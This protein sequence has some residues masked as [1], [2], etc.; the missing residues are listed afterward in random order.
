MVWPRPEYFPFAST[1]ERPGFVGL[2]LFLSLSACAGLVLAPRPVRRWTLGAAGAAILLVWLTKG[3]HPP[4]ADLNAA[5]Y[6]HVPGMWLF[7]EPQSKSGPLLVALL[8]LGSALLVGEAGGRWARRGLAGMLVGA[9]LATSYPIWTGSVIPDQRPLLPPA[10]V[11]FPRYWLETGRYLSHH[12]GRVL[13]LPPDDYYQVP[14]RWGFY[15]SDVFADEL[16]GLVDRP[17]AAA[18]GQRGRWLGPSTAQ[19]RRH[20]GGRAGADR[21]LSATRRGLVR[22]GR[23]VGGP[24]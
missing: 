3:L 20:L 23:G 6:R 11:R 16:I 12:P 7:R 9:T 1:L 14:Y 10:H 5:L 13:L 21:T 24:Y 22:G 15:G 4:L 17:P 2:R 19:R 18:D 8:T